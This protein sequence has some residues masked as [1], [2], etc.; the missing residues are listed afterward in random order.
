MLSRNIVFV[1]EFYSENVAFYIS[2]HIYVLGFRYTIGDRSA[3]R[4]VCAKFISI[5]IIYFE[6]V[7]RMYV[8]TDVLFATKCDKEI[9][10]NII[11]L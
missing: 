7:L 2:T 11:Q 3:E 9:G 4:D 5:L 8:R 6:D 1:K 10:Y